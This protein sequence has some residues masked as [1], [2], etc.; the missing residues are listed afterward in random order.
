M[1]VFGL[2]FRYFAE[3]YNIAYMDE[4]W[5]QRDVWH[6]YERLFDASIERFAVLAVEGAAH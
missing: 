6:E 2:D 5:D 1:L 3:E 4:S